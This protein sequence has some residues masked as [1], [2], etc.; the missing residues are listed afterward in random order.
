LRSAVGEMRIP[1]GVVVVARAANL[2]GPDS[3]LKSGDVIH[4]VNL[5]SVESVDSL[6][7]ALNQL[8]AN[9]PCVLQIERDGGLEWLAFEME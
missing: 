8:K 7:K 9:G 6:R 2:I 3:G 5:T 1:S 4:S